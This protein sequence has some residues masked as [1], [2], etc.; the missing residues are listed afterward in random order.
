MVRMCAADVPGGRGAAPP[1]ARGRSR[2]RG[3]AQAPVRG[4]GHPRVAPIVP[5]V[6]LVEDPVIEEQDETPAT[7]PALVDFMTVPGFLEVMGRC[8]DLSRE[9]LGIP[10]YV[11]TLVGDSVVVDRVYQSYV[12]TFCGYETRAYLLLLDMV[13]FEVILGMDWFSPYHAIL[14]C[15]AKTVT[16]AMPELPRIEWRGSF[17]CT[18]SRVVSFLKARHMVEKGCLASLAFVQDNT[19]ETPALDSVP[20]V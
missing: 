15:Y 18:Y 8:C 16:L 11:S 5:P 3:R 14:D 2:G 17:V 20:V 1:I 12:V 6:D 9:S 13:D 10:V 7:E 19:A 4:R